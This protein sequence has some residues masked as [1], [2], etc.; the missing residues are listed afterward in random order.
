M[1][2]R[3]L[4]ACEFSGVVRDAF[5]AAGH[6]AWSCDFL[7]SPTRSNR[8]IHGDVLNYLN[9]GWDLL[10]IAHPPC[11]RLCLSG[12]RWLHEP[13]TK[14]NPAHHP[15]WECDAYQTWDR[16]TRLAFMWRKLDEGAAFF[17]RLWNAPI[18]RVCAENPVMHKYGRQRID[19]WVKPQIVQPWHHGDAAFKA[20]GLYL[21]NLKP[22]VETNRLVTPRPGT[23]EHKEWSKVHLAVPGPDRWKIRSEFFPG[24]AA[25]MAHQWGGEPTYSYSIAA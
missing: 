24:I 19:N 12:V 3:V 4:V 20:T 7:P 23:P 10:M 14:L 9:E 2:L 17:N 18:E 22:L 21:R 15:L 6:D 13:P 1:P 16:D 5:L 25:A 11:T 8:H